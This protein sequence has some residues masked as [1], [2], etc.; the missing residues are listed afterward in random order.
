MYVPLGG[1]RSTLRR[2]LIN[3]GIVFLISGV[4]HGAAWSYVL[5]GAIH[6]GCVVAE[7]RMKSTSFS[8]YFEIT[9][10][11]VRWGLTFFVV[12]VSWVFFQP[13]MEPAIQQLGLM[14]GVLGS[15]AASV[16]SRSDVAL[17]VFC[18]TTLLIVQ[19]SLRHRSPRELFDAHPRFAGVT[20]GVM[21]LLTMTATGESLDFLYFQF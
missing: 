10:D 17:V 15:G 13:T 2:T 14:F 18:I 8:R 12:L 3:L 1:S 5:W 7:K 21:I 6:G 20:L 4:W 9:P 16:V 11:F 19:N